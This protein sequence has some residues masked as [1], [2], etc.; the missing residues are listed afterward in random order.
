[1]SKKLLKLSI[2]LAAIMI[3]VSGCTLPWSKKEAPAPIVENPGPNA[4]ATSSPSESTNTSR[5]KKFDNYEQLAEFLAANNNPEADLTRG[6]INSRLALAPPSAA[7]MTS[8]AM[9]NSSVSD[10]GGT[11]ADSSGVNA[12]GYSETNNQVK[13]VDEADII[14]TDGTY[15]YALV[16]NELSIIKAQPAS[17]AS[18]ISKITL[19]SRPQDIFIDGNHLAV[20]GSDDQ[21]YAQPLYATFRRRGAYTFFKV[22]DISDPA[23]PK[24]VRDLDFEGSYYDARLVGDYVYFITNTYSNYI[25]NEPLL[26][27]VLD[28]GQALGAQCGGS[29]KCFA[30]D[31]YYFDIPY[32]SY[33]FTNIT[34]INIKNNDEAISGETYLLSSS[35]NLYVSQKN[36]YITYTQYLSEYDLE[37]SVKRELLFPKLS[38]DNQDKIAKIEAAPSFVLNN[39]EKKIKVAQIIDW[40]LNSLSESDRA[41]I[42]AEIDSGLKQKLAEKAKE[43]EKT[44]IHKI[45]IN[46]SKLEY[47][48]MG[49][50]SGHVLNQF[51]M[52]ENDNYFRIATTR[53]QQSSRFSDLTSDSYSNVYILDA[54]LKVVGSLENLATAERIYAVRFLGDRAYL[55]TFKQTDPLFVISLSDPT[56][57][58]VLGALK[59]PGFSNYLHPV[60]ADGSKLIGLGRDTEETAG[61]GVKIKGLKLSLFDFS[62]LTK[63]KELDSYLIGDASSDSIALYDHKAFL[64]SADK[65]LLVIPAVLRDNGRLSF[66]GALVFS[67]DNNQLKL[68]GRIDHSA[69]GHFAQADYWG[70]FDYYDNTVKRSLYINNDLFTFSNKFLK[71]NSLADLSEVKSLELTAGGDDYIITTPPVLTPDTAKTG[72][73][74]ATSTEPVLPPSETGTSTPPATSTPPVL[75]PAST[76]STTPGT[77][78]QP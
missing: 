1:M 23:N 53:A 22:F 19:K 76:P 7:P 26:P 70:G 36:I 37:Q 69:G 13:G 42:Q 66:A 75:P 2:S 61:G 72:T 78:T 56:K 47:R 55:V 39:N 51:S 41:A 48:A 60:D 33:N 45:A 5:L 38:A 25:A 30:P 59:I 77:S 4:N 16:R 31:V 43:M 50:V 6:A 32:N 63:P 58:V 10:S 35:Q 40:Y 44:I 24:Q 49:E 67:L 18:V 73:G 74:G 20:F 52:D 64:Y 71:V 65:N 27:R 15:I 57:P 62:D 17:A 3:I 9:V 8:E 68:R 46:G 14:K 34:A 29:Q 28:N 21:I 12:L 11:G 54:N